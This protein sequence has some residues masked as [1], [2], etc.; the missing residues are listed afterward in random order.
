MPEKKLNNE[1]IQAYLK[2]LHAGTLTNN[3]RWQLEKAS[4]DDP[5]LEDA[6]EGY[7]NNTCLLY[8][9]PSPRD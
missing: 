1:Q 5:F 3:E 6:L 2:K 9:S 4:L 8:T 7:Y